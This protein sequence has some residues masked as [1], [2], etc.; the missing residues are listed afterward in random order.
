MQ[1]LKQWGIDTW[2]ASSMKCIRFDVCKN[3]GLTMWAQD[4][5]LLNEV[6]T[7]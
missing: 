6:H 7:F 2:N 5:S 3:S 4:G 1:G